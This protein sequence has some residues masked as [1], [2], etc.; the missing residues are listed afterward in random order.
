MTKSR[1]KF[2][3][4]LAVMLIVS[5]ALV[6]AVSAEPK[7]EIAITEEVGKAVKVDAPKID[8]M[9][10]TKTSQIVQVDDILISL[11]ANP[12]HTEAVIEVEDLI[13]KEK[14]IISYKISK[15]ADKFTTEIYSEGEL[16]NTVI[17]DYDP[18][19]P[20]VTLDVLKNNAKKIEDM[21]QVTTL[22][23]SYYWDGVPFVKGSGIKYPHPDYNSY[24]G[25]EVW[26]TW[27]INGND[28]T[29]YHM[30][31]TWSGPIAELSPAI[32]GA[33]IGSRAGPQAA[34]AGAVLGLLLGGITSGALLDEEG[35]IW[36][37]YSTSWEWIILPV[38]PYLYYI[39]KYFRISEYTLWDKMSK[40]NP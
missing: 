18:L 8:I 5:M 21:S 16:F 35:S 22:A 31:D 6:P 11:K 37:W 34:V 38:A 13:T 14:K 26:E 29:H 39:P 4:L 23:T 17:L 1:I 30:S 15:K 10:N 12:Q 19:E 20:G 27:K 9:E 2:G 33:I 24:P 3:A 25:W 7:S 32:A 36:Y 40:G 28:L